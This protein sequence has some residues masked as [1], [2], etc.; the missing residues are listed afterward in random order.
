MSRAIHPGVARHPR[1]VAA[2]LALTLAASLLLV[3]AVAGCNRQ[4]VTVKLSAQAHEKIVPLRINVRAEVS[5]QTALLSYK[6]YADGGKCDPQESTVPMTVF[7]FAL[8]SPRDTV[9]LDV[10]EKG[11]RVG[12]AT[13]ELNKAQFNRVAAK[14]P[15][16]EYRITITGI[17][18]A[19]TGG[20]DTRAHISGTVS[21]DL[22]DDLRVLVYARAGGVWFIQPLSQSFHTLAADGTWS[23]WTHVGSEYAALLVLPEYIAGRTLD[24]IPEVNEHILAR[25]VV[26]GTAPKG[27]GH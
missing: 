9:T 5:G 16:D 21:G 7:S 15:G 3:M 27:S 11:E 12:Q 10:W 14:A 1:G 25:A 22:S 17:P 23:T 2:F 24:S 4:R 18:P 19:G 6:W 26:R 13:I 20:A 8:G